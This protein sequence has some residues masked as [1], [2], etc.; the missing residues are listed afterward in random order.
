MK[1][2]AGSV[3][4]NTKELCALAGSCSKLLFTVY[5]EL[6]QKSN[7]LVSKFKV[8][9]LEIEDRGERMIEKDIL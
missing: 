9:M 4:Y 3:I 1:A 8:S 6:Y 7:G 2:A 5:T